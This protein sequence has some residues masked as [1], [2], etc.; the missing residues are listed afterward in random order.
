MNFNEVI[1]TELTND[2]EFVMK[3]LYQKK[4]L[5]PHSG[6]KCI[7]IENGI[8][9]AT[10]GNRL[11]WTLYKDT[12]ITDGNYGIVSVDKKAKMIVLKKEDVDFVNWKNI[13]PENIGKTI[14]INESIDKD[15][16][17][18]DILKNVPHAIKI[19]YLEDIHRGDRTTW[20]IGI[21]SFDEMG[22]K[23]LLFVSERVAVMMM[24]IEINREPITK[25]GKLPTETLLKRE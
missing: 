2:I 14:E 20:T 17:V 5:P 18:L 24:G 23:I 10:D 13:I 1:T 6:I 3:A 8:M 4:D 25:E 12:N 19:K 16:W 22:S 21:Q 15:I 7:H 9:V 11:H